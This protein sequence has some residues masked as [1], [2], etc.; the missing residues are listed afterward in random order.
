[1]WFVLVCQVPLHVLTFFILKSVESMC[2]MLV[3][4]QGV[5][6]LL[7]TGSSHWL[8]LSPY[9]KIYWFN[10]KILKTEDLFNF[11]LLLMSMLS[12]WIKSKNVLMLCSFFVFCPTIATKMSLYILM[13]KQVSIVKGRLAIIRKVRLY[14][15]FVSKLLKGP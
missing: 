9:C 6:F 8:L 14:S 7:H 5:S 4:W 12:R 3:L 2:T 15:P 13:Q 11:V 10:Q 1:M